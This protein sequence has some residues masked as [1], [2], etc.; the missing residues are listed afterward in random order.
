MTSSKQEPPRRNVAVFFYP[1]V[2]CLLFC[3]IF[4]YLWLRIDPSLVY[5]QAHRLPSFISVTDKVPADFL[6][7]PGGPTG[8]LAN[9]LSDHYFDALLGAR[10]IA[11]LMAVVCLATLAAITPLGLRGGYV[12]AIGPPL[13][14]VF[15]FGQ[16]S[17]VTTLSLRL[18]AACLLAGAYMRIPSRR[19][20]ARALLFVIMTPLVYM[21]VGEVYF[22]FAL[23][24]GLFEF[25]KRRWLVGAGSLLLAL[26]IPCLGTIWLLEET[27]NV[28]GTD[29]PWIARLLPMFYHPWTHFELLVAGEYVTTTA[30]ALCLAAFFILVAASRLVWQLVRPPRAAARKQAAGAA[31]PPRRAEGWTSYV[32]QMACLLAVGLLIFNLFDGARKTRLRIDYCA[33]NEMWP[34]LL[35]AARQDTGG[36]DACINY[37]VNQALYHTGQLPHAMFSYPQTLQGVSLIFHLQDKGDP[38]PL[39]RPYFEMGRV[40]EAE[41]IACETIEIYGERPL[42]IRLLADI[43]IVKKRPEAARIY[44]RKLRKY[45]KYTAEADQLLARLE[46]DPLLSSDPEVRHIRSLM[47]T[48]DFVIGGRKTLLANRWKVLLQ[49]NRRNQKAFEYLMAHYLLSRQ[50]LKFVANLHRLDDFN[51]RVIPRHYEEAILIYHAV[52][53]KGLELGDRQI[54][55]E[56]FRRFA[57]FARS[58]QEFKAATGNRRIQVLRALARQYDDT[59]YYYFYFGPGGIAL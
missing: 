6:T 37:C 21:M 28:M 8:Y 15:L 11:V 43:N 10:I 56:T 46:D 57:D 27:V 59:F 22:L 14:L 40:N 17:D 47:F 52:S 5:H 35:A 32:L 41:R 3:L 16:Y 7:Y 42:P 26:A 29:P 9:L 55:P 49:T 33:E 34:E 50:V 36:Y 45:G 38:C 12:V 4:L 18:A 51:Y 48:R 39:G 13:L 25:L 54:R 1:L 53:K 31:L 20:P 23:I 58:F 2:F 30:A 19:L 44:L 24:C